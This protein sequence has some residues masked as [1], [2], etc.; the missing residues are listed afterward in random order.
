MVG[1]T[2]SHYKVIEKIGRGGMGEVYLA[3]DTTLDRKV[4]LKFLP[5]ELQ[6][7][8]AARKRFL[9]EAKS[10]AALDHP[11]ICKIY[12]VGEAEEKSF[13]SMEYIRG[14][15]LQ[16]KLGEGPRPLRDVLKTAGE[17]AEALEAAHEQEIVHRD[18][19]PSNIMLTPKGYVKVMDFGLAK[20]VVPVEGQDEEITT[21]LTRADSILG[22]VP[23]MSP[24]QIRGQTVDTRSDIFSFGV[25]LYEMLAGVHPFKKGGQ[26]ETAS[27]ILSEEP[28]PMSDYVQE[29]PEALQHTVQKLLVKR[30]EGRCQS[31]TEVLIDLGQIAA[32]VPITPG[33][34]R[35]AAP[36]T[37]GKTPA[38]AV[39][40]S[41]GKFEGLSPG[42]AW[43][44]LVWVVMALA[45][46]LWMAEQSRLSQIVPLPKSPELLVA[47]ARAI[48]QDLGYPT[49][50]RDSTN[51]FSSDSSYI[52]DLMSKDRSNT[53]WELLARGEPSVIRFWYRE[54]PQYLVPEHDPPLSVPGMVSLQLDTRGRLRQLEA[55]PADFDD[56]GADTLEADWGSLF[57]A[58]KLDPE[59]F[60][61]DE[62]QLSPSSRA[63][64]RV[65]WQGTYPDAPE[66]P[67]RIEAAF[68][69]GRTVAFQILE[70]WNEPVGQGRVSSGW[71]R[72]EEVVPDARARF[73]LVGFQLLFML[74]LAFL[75]RHNLRAGR[76]DR[77]L[78]FRLAC[79]FFATVLLQ[80]V[81][82]TH[83]VPELSQVEVFFGVLYR[84][85][86]AF[87]LAWLFYI[88][89]EPYAQGLWPQT[90]ISW[91]RLLEG[92]VRDPRVGRDVLL[93][94]AYGIGGA[95]VMQA[96][97]LAPVWLGSVPGR[98]DFPYDPAE[99]IALRGVK[100]SLAQLFANQLDI[101]IHILN[102]IVGLLLLRFV[103]RRTWLAVGVHAA[104]YVAI[105]GSGFG[106]LGMVLWIGLWYLVLFRCGWLAILVGT[107]TNDLLNGYPLTT[108]LW[109]WYAHASIL[110]VL[111]CLGLTLY[112]F[113]VSLGGRP[114][115]KDLLAEG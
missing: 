81:F 107:F 33:S 10:A 97:R 99:L 29:C 44:C 30:V 58:A 84:A 2:I 41:A 110:V 98:P 79:F 8:S 11:F 73:A 27:A 101:S 52:D 82:G 67:I 55:V 103:F 76:G 64:R 34:D 115:L 109:A 100:E 4:A 45:G 24:E 16:E 69:R 83:H 59:D 13:I 87:G 12:E 108:D 35:R 75:T 28:S 43:T 72:S 36:V 66:I 62:P 105:Y 46:T 3:Q 90:L 6:Q 47:D 22:T 112:G 50:Q 26:I 68:F 40:T 60:T 5:E 48:L 37:R 57:A 38:P 63:Y 9:R 23:Y 53:W 39:V 71:V 20:R 25:V 111:V 19:K 7:D 74:T 88:A 61:P 86:F 102:L 104:L 85:F 1:Q 15:T 113:K 77:R 17:I 54:S 96:F 106:F 42:V 18:L 93:G 14:T 114:V 95:L 80:W 49:P 56:S 94:C 92:R 21:V 51:G 70:P 91:V 78:A 89:L 31:A 32:S 65:A